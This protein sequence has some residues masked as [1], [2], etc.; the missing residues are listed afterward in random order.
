MVI[1]IEY[2]KPIKVIIYNDKYFYETKIELTNLPIINI[3]TEDDITTNDTISTFK[4]I[5]LNNKKQV[6]SNNSMIHIRGASSAIVD[7]KSYKVEIYN[8]K[9]S[10][11]K[12]IHIDN[13]YFGSDFILDA[14]YKDPSKIRNVLATKLWN[15]ISNDFTK[16]DI[17]YEFVELFIND[18]YMG[19]YVFTEPINR[20]R[21]NLNKD[22]QNDTSIIIKSNDWNTLN[23][24]SDFKNIN[25]DK[26]LGYEIKYPNDDKF[27]SDIWNKFLTKISN[28]YDDFNSLTYDIIND[29]WN[30]NN[31]I[32]MIIYNAFINNSD[33]KL[34]KNDYFYMKSLKS[35]EIYIQPWDMEFSFGLHFSSIGKKLSVK[36]LNDYNQVYTSFI[37]TDPKI[38][39]LL[40]SRYTALRKNIL[41][42]K[43]FDK[44]LD[45]YKNKLINGATKRDSDKWYKYDIEQEIEEIRTWISNRLDY[46]DEYVS[47]LKNE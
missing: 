26:Y 3:R 16:V 30:L 12:N 10:E 39:E 38:N 29:T 44:L 20:K 22:S 7:K 40:V 4:Y 15:D 23:N 45:E 36:D 46:F 19:L 42:K 35:N 11:E 31:Y 21:L 18:E 14:V 5:N 27:Y 34:V 25:D 6:V 8:N 13:F 2:N 43:Y 24:D 41:T 47:D 37:H 9:Y 32:D 1:K 28:Y 33:N 17:Y